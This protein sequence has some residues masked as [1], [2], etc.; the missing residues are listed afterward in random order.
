MQVTKSCAGEKEIRRKGRL[1]DESE[2]RAGRDW[3]NPG[4]S[5]QAID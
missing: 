1:S 5:L 3:R 2:L 4:Q